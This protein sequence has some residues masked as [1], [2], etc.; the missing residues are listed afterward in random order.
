MFKMLLWFTGMSIGLRN[1]KDHYISDDSDST[2]VEIATEQY[3]EWKLVEIATE[4][5]D[6]WRHTR[7]WLL[8]SQG[9]GKTETTVEDPIQSM[10]EE[11]ETW[12]SSR[13]NSAMDAW[14]TTLSLLIV[15][16]EAHYLVRDQG[17]QEA[18]FLVRHNDMMRFWDDTKANK[19]HTSLFGIH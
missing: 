16:Q 17:Q 19:R 9:N 4:Q 1:Y 18:H 10:L 6:E 14:S 11:R 2:F 13:H 8:M 12:S 15:Q 3:D 7:R 5:Y